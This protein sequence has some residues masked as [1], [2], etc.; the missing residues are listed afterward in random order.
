MPLKVVNRHQGLSQRK[1][2]TL[3]GSEANHQRADQA[4]PSCHRDGVE[5]GKRDIGG[6]H[7]LVNHGQNL[8]DMLARGD[9]GDHAAEPLVNVDL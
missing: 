2:E 9:L 7:R 1:R 6:P 4:G 3:R 5:F 8:A